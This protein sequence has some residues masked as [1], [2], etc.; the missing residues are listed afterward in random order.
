MPKFKM[1]RQ[2]RYGDV[3]GRTV[4]LEVARAALE[5]GG[6][7]TRMVG[8]ELQYYVEFDADSPEGKLLNQTLKGY[9]SPFPLNYITITVDLK[10]DPDGQ[11]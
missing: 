9:T 1:W 10:G 8:E 5:R 7:P 4:P 2:A 11:A 6:Y 3:G